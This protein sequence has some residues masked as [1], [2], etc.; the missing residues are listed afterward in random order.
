M[1]SYQTTKVLIQDSHTLPIYGTLYQTSDTQSTHKPTIFYLHGGGLV[2]GQRDDLP[3]R[4]IT[5]L[6]NAGYNLFTIDYPLAPE[7]KLSEILS[8]IDQSITWFENNAVDQLYLNNNDFILMGRSAGA[9]LAIYQAVYHQ[10]KAKGLITF[11][12]YFNLNEAAFNVPN[13]YFL[14]FPKVSDAQV[15]KLINNQPITQ[16]EMNQRYPIYISARQKGNWQSLYLEEN[17][18]ATDFS[19]PKKSLSS[20]PVS[21]IAAATNDPDVPSRQ[22]KF[23]H[24]GNA[25]SELHLI[26]SDQHDFDRTDIETLGVDIY[27]KLI[28]WLNK[29]FS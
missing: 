26:E 24:K 14:S 20:L 16:G 18:S 21:F 29:N 2:F 1:T 9:Y 19:I 10:S 5:M 22:S 23:L 15:A 11:Y 6:T 13:R 12:G 3:E 4:Y 17:Q 28:T 7:S 25:N 8:S 27:E